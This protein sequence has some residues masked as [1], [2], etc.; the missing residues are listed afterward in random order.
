MNVLRA[1]R[2]VGYY[3]KGVAITVH[4]DVTNTEYLDHVRIS[5]I[6][7]WKALRKKFRTISDQA[8]RITE[9]FV[10]KHTELETRI[11]DE[12]ESSMQGVVCVAQDYTKPIGVLTGNKISLYL[13]GGKLDVGQCS[14]I[15]SGCTRLSRA[16]LIILI[17]LALTAIDIGLVHI[18]P[19]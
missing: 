15:H 8:T 10:D 13:Y 1:C 14:Q 11:D 17:F 9:P 4:G 3:L 2:W 6:F 7:S 5:I 19:T 16:R 12:S 18:I